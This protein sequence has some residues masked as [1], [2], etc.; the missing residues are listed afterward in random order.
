MK[1]IQHLLLKLSKL[2]I[3]NDAKSWGNALLKLYNESLEYTDE[4]YD[5][6]FIRRICQLSLKRDH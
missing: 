4:N 1:N 6:Y 2:L 5:T 3:N